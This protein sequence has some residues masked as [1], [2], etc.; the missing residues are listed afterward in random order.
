MLPLHCIGF[1]IEY[2][3]RY[4]PTAENFICLM[5]NS[6]KNIFSAFTAERGR[7]AIMLEYSCMF[8]CKNSHRFPMHLCPSFVT[9]LSGGNFLFRKQSL[10]TQIL[11]WRIEKDD[12]VVFQQLYITA[13]S[14]AC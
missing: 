5:G 4:L 10:V 6:L 14:M 13:D 8:S 2:L 12:R 9:K 1:C 7:E 11:K 3:N